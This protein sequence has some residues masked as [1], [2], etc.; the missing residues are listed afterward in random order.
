MQQCSAAPE[1]PPAAISL[2]ER[3]SN[4]RAWS[5]EQ[6]LEAALRDLRSSDRSLSKAN[7]AVLIYLRDNENDYVPGYYAQNISSSE[8]MGLCSYMQHW[9]YERMNDGSAS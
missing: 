8:V 1:A 6:M 2:A 5:L 3:T 9:M 4:N 7:R